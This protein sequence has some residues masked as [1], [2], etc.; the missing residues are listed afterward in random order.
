MQLIVK[1]FEEL[2]VEELYE[3]LKIRV[4]VFVVEQNCPYQEIDGKD[5]QSFH[6][7]LKDDDGIQAYLRVIDKGV[8]YDEVSIGR[9]IAVKRRNGIGSKILS[10]GIKVAK[11][12]LKA[13]AIRIEAQTYAKEFYEK[14]G[15]KQVSGIFLEDGIPHVQMLLDCVSP[16]L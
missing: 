3:I 10:E 16:A 4:S 8:S 6:V 2:T 12:K 1:R 14:Q 13:T 15:F 5:K 7:Y 11:S 9:V